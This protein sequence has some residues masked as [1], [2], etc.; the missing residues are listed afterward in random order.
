MKCSIDVAIRITHGREQGPLFR[1]IKSGKSPSCGFRESM[2]VHC[3]LSG[4]MYSVELYDTFLLCFFFFFIRIFNFVCTC[5]FSK[6]RKLPSCGMTARGH[7]SGEM[8]NVTL[9]TV[10]YCVF[11]LFFFFSFVY[12]RQCS[13]FIGK[14]SNVSVRFYK[15][16][17]ISQFVYFYARLYQKK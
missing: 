1:I 4:E 7:M 15:K 14:C 5:L 13:V 11:S 8:C 16:F 10:F 17:Q 2:S 3:E 12:T 9:Y 6:S